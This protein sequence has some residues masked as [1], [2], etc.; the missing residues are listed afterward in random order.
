M[1]GMSQLINEK[2]DFHANINI[3]NIAQEKIAELLA[4]EE[5]GMCFRAQVVGGGCQGLRYEFSLD[6]R[7]D[8]DYYALYQGFSLVAD[9]ISY[10]YL[11]GASID[12]AVTADGELFTVANPKEKSR[13]SCGSSFS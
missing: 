3:S 8:E 9:A 5:E 11:E 2:E 1:G 4:H 12:Y 6:E 13:C 10:P 7:D